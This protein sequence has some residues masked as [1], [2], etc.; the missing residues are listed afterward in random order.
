MSR[1]DTRRKF[2]LIHWAVENLHLPAAQQPED[3]PESDRIPT[4]GEM[5][6]YCGEYAV[7]LT[8][9]YAS[10]NSL[11]LLV[12]GVAPLKPSDQ[13]VL[14][15]A[16]FNFMRGREAIT[17]CRGIRSHML[18]RA[19]DAMMFAFMR[20]RGDWIVSEQMLSA[21]P[22]PLKRP[23]LFERAIIARRVVLVSLGG[24]H[25]SVLRGFTRQSWL[26]FDATGRH[27]VLRRPDCRDVALRPI[28]IVSRGR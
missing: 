16:G 24:G 20:R 25:F 22:H 1:L 17:P 3:W 5:P 18:V 13:Q 26:L 7:G 12:A 23:I 27:W 21:G 14:L 2:A 10:L 15:E 6:I 9:L 19:A 28:L 11:K 8:G 4:N